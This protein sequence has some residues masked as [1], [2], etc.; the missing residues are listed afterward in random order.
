[1]SDKEAP[2]KNMNQLVKQMYAF[3]FVVIALYYYIGGMA[4]GSILV[5]KGTPEQ[6]YVFGNYGSGFTFVATED[7]DH[8]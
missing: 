5:N 2:L 4:R 8:A 1:M 6:M 7:C 3:S